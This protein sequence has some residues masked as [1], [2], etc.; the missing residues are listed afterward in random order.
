M[1]ETEIPGSYED[2][3]PNSDSCNGGAGN[4]AAEWC[5]TTSNVP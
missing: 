5:E 1:S 3:D 2:P 4:D